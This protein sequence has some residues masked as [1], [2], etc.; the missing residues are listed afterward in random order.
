[1]LSNNYFCRLESIE[2]FSTINALRKDSEKL[3]K[4]EMVPKKLSLNDKVIH[5]CCPIILKRVKPYES[6]SA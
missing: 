1:M 6:H 2:F 3:Y 4:V 5:L